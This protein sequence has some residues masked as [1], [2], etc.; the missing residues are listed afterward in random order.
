MRALQKQHIV[1]VYVWVD[2]CLPKEVKPGVKSVLRDSEVLTIP[3][4]NLLTVQQQT[5]RQVYDWT[6]QYHAL[7]FPKLPS[8]QS[9]VIA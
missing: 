6:L 9:I 7:D 4:F 1:D 5:L 3:T 2:D 8:C